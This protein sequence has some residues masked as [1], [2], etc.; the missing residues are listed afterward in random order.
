M[1]AKHFWVVGLVMGL[2]VLMAGVWSAGAQDA[3]DI[4]HITI[5]ATAE[6]FTVPEETPEGIVQVTFANNSET[7]IIPAIVRLNG[8]HLK[9]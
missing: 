9:L 2:L 5:E 3:G 7:P 8:S 4:P 6:G 1:H